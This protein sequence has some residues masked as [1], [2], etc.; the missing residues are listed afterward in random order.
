VERVA[1]RKLLQLHAT[2]ELATLRIPPGNQ[3]ATTKSP[4]ASAF[5]SNRRKPDKNLF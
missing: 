1:W 5:F 2:S 4:P 3:L